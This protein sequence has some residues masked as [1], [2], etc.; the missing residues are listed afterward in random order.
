MKKRESK[1]V[2]FI[3]ALRV[4]E[5]FAE[6]AHEAIEKLKQDLPHIRRMAWEAFIEIAERGEQLSWPPKFLTEKGYVHLSEALKLNGIADPTAFYDGCAAALIEAARKGR[7]IEWPP[8]F[9]LRVAT[10]GG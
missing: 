3:P 10:A 9:R 2:A 7:T 4:P 1:K 8:S 5:E 6:R